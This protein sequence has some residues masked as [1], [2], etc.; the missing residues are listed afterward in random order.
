MNWEQT[1]IQFR[2]FLK[3]ER[4]LSGNSID[5][6]E[7]DIRKLVAFLEIKK[8]T[9]LPQQIKLEDLKNFIE[10]INE[11]GLHARSQMR[12]ISGLKSFF[13]FLLLDNQIE[14]DPT[15]LLESPK[16][17]R[18]LPEV[19]SILEI[20][21]IIA[22]IDLSTPEGQRNKAIIETMY[23][24]GLRVSELVNLKITNLY[25]NDGFIK[26]IG[27]GSKERLVPIGNKAIK[28]IELYY[29]YRNLLPVIDKASQ[30]IVFLNRR[31]KQLTRVMI[32]TIVKRLAE[33]AQIKKTISPHTFRHSF[34]TH[35]IDGGADLRA[36]QEMLGHESILTTEIYTHLDRE[37]L[38][39]AI[40][41]FHPRA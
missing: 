20:D 23:S 33:K 25:F 9:T 4:S 3:L 2:N 38:R 11:L 34:A 19:L 16:T 39:D 1:I 40:I 10:W 22:A 24:C 41:R 27:K 26:V 14:S 21:Q 8:Q 18:K 5:A 13:K 12:I 6:Y 29:T 37:Y 32:F 7:T 30:N 28:E 15:R 17:G 36:V 31:G 35:L